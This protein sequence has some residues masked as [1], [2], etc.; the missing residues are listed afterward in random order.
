MYEIQRKDLAKASSVLALAF[1][2]YPLF[3]HVLPDSAS[4]TDRLKHLCRFL[5]RLGMAK[6][7]VVAPSDALEGV[8]IWLPSEGSANSA[9]DAVKAGLFDLFFHV[10]IRAIG[11]FIEIGKAK[12]RKRK[13]I[14]GGSY[15]LCDMIGVDPL[16]QGRGAGRH[17]MEAQL[18]Y[19]DKAKMPCYLETSDARNVVYYEKYGFELIH[20]Y[21]IHGVPVF[22]LQWKPGALREVSLT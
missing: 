11:R 5:L 16:Q 2:G 8:S 13:E 14:V 21:E 7:A 9:I 19:L 4:R 15:W 6:G 12:A 17:M 20:R 10:D 18:D 3:E 22:C 1:T